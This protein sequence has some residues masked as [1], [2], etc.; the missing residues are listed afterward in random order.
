MAQVFSSLGI[1]L[2][3]PIEV[4]GGLISGAFDNIQMCM[5]DDS[6]LSRLNAEYHAVYLLSQVAK[7]RKQNVS[8]GMMK[9]VTDN[10][11]HS[12]AE[13]Y[14]ASA[15]AAMLN[16]SV[17]RFNHLFK[18]SVGC[19]PYAYYLKL[20]MENAVSLLEDTN[21]KIKDIAR[22]CGY[23]DPLYFAQVFKRMRGLTPAEYRRSNSMV[24]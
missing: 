7:K 20:R 2:L 23:E 8:Y 19:S 12:F 6:P 4:R 1:A 16:I 11:E 10:M 24:R 3:A 22:Q 17:S 13:D 5:A 18:E 14:D 21:M 9:R 15:Y